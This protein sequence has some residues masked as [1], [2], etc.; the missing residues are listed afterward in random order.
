A[1]THPIEEYVMGKFVKRLEEEGLDTIDDR[2]ALSFNNLIDMAGTL[3]KQL[4]ASRSSRELEELKKKLDEVI[5]DRDMIAGTS[6]SRITELE[7]R[8]AVQEKEAEDKLVL[9]NSRVSSLEEEK[10]RLVAAHEE[11]MDT[12]YANFLIKYR[13]SE[14][15]EDDMYDAQ[16]QGMRDG[17]L[18]AFKKLK[19]HGCL[20]G[21]ALRVAKSMT[22]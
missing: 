14:Q 17:A 5:Q 9:A 13:S 4:R 22:K 12:A 11:A 19:R 8:L 16:K 6:Y 21:V 2:M 15:F 3:S 1:I 10:K 7:K 20:S 18:E